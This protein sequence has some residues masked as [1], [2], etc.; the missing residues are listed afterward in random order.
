[1]QSKPSSVL[2]PVVGWWSQR[3]LAQRF[4]FLTAVL[5]VGSAIAQGAIL[6]GISSYFVGDLERERV[7]QRVR[8]AKNDLATRLE[9]FRKSPLL[10][11]GTPP[12]EAIIR[13]STGGTRAEGESLAIWRKRLGII[14][15]SVMQA[16]PSLQQAR[17][18]G[19]ADGGRE[20]VRVNRNEQGFTIVGEADLQQKGSRR[21]FKET[22][23]LDPGEVYLSELDANSENGILERPFR[24]TIR[25]ATPIYSPSGGLFGIIVVNGAPEVWLRTISALSGLSGNLMLANQDGDYVYRSND[26]PIFGSLSGMGPGFERDWP[27]LDGIFRPGGPSMLNLR[28]GDQFVT[29]QRLY[30]NPASRKQFVV[31]AEE[32]SAT[33]AFG[34]TRV[35]IFV[36]ALVAL[37]MGLIGAVAAY[38][39]SR[40]LKGLMA[41][42][43]QIAQGKLDVEKLES[44]GVNVETG[45]LG[46][47]LR[48][49]KEAI[50]SREASLHKSE[51]QLEAIVANTID[52]LITIAPDGAILRYN[53]GCE[54][55]FGYSEKEATGR[56]ISLLIP[57]AGHSQVDDHAGLSLLVGK[58]REVLGRHKNGN[59]I[60][61]EVAIAE[62]SVGDEVLLTGVVQDVTE[63]KKAERVKSE[64]VSNMSHEIR[65]PLNSIS[66]FTQLLLERDDLFGEPRDQVE[67]IKNA[68]SALITIVND[69]LDYSKLD[70]GKIALSPMPFSPAK[71]GRDCV[72]IVAS[73]ADRIDLPV[74]VDVDESL[75]DAVFI[76]DP[77]RLQQVLL[78][79]LG[80][81]IKFTN[82]GS[83]T[84]SIEELDAGEGGSTVRFAVAD[85]GIGIRSEDLQHLFQRFSQV[86]SSISRNYGGTGLGLAICKKLVALMGGKI[87]VASKLGEGST[88][89]FCVPL[90]RAASDTLPEP[91]DTRSGK[92]IAGRRLILVVEDIELNQEIAVAMLEGAGHYV[93]VADNGAEA[94]RMIRDKSY[95]LIL[96]DIQMPVMDGVTATKTIRAMKG[97]AGRVPII[98]MTANVLP[99]EVRRFFAA[100]MNGHIRKP[101]DRN[102]LIVAVD[103][104]A[105]PPKQAVA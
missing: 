5:I 40:P 69:I 75:E 49:M 10:L 60:D 33:A 86:D 100:G 68:A 23:R 21:Y 104:F 36:G 7:E 52:G 61:I 56:N 88:F 35:L 102:D 19:V 82:Q 101:V 17:F 12:I 63:R 2:Q 46:A 70:E 76:G 45:E 13:L 64:F 98:A 91:E 29:A 43:K 28:L 71:L 20:I 41:A 80:N 94:V 15:R 3:S 27:Q 16:T 74:S 59:P 83:V 97:D 105:A 55:I 72:S 25:A 78:N 53:R 95:D 9:Q 65:T 31:L 18:V 11:S 90:R 38:F 50:E 44:K 79:L 84:L 14:F 51:A 24:P 4:A 22:T 37:A 96:M 92:P 34:D 85:T 32:T 57:A 73:I 1:M 30:Y 66:G 8:A 54:A 67:K 81:A 89:S 6:V 39:V 103:R 47:A 62:I 77:H 99:D 93:E 87:R 48:I 58:R 26:G 42:A